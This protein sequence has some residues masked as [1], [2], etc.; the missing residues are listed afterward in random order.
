VIA[1]QTHPKVLEREGEAYRDLLR[2]RAEDLGV[3]DDVEFEPGYRNPDALMD[4]VSSADVVLLPY[5]ST[6]QAT[7]G[8][9]VEAVAAARPIVA[10]RFPHAVELLEGGA[11]LLVPHGDVPAMTEALR[12]V[13]TGPEAAASMTQA[14]G[15]V[16]PSL[17][18]SAVADSYRALAASLLDAPIT[19]GA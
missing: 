9:L 4:L 7:S 3:G 8:V 5:D 10:T 17:A 11:G 19:T 16:A 1:G 2:A 13:L 15:R 6:E 12:T 18:W 14:S